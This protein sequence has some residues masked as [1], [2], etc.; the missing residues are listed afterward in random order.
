MF[1]DLYEQVKTTFVN[2]SK[3]NPIFQDYKERAVI[4]FNRNDFREKNNVLMTA[5]S[6]G[7]THG[8]L[9]VPVRDIY[10]KGPVDQYD[11]CT[12]LHDSTKGPFQLKCLQGEFIRQGGQET[13]TLYPSNENIAFW[14]SLKQWIYVKETIQNIITQTLS[15]N[16][17]VKENAMKQFY[18]I[19][20]PKESFA[21]EPQNGV[22]LFWFTHHTD[23]T[24][25]TTFLGRR[26][27]PSIPFLNTNISESGS[28]IFFTSIVSNKLTTAKYR[29]SSLNGFSLYFNNSITQ[30]FNNKSLNTTNEL[31]SLHNGG[32]VTLESSNIQLTPDVNRLYGFLYYAKGQAYYK[33]EVLSDEFGPG[34][35]ELPYTHLQMTQEPFAPMISFEIEKS[36]Q[37]WGCDYPFCDKR[38]SGFKMKWENDGW[39]GPS[40]QYR[41]ESLNQIQ[42]PLKKNYFSF[43]NGKCAIRSKF[44]FRLNSFITLTL[45]LTIQSNV[46]PGKIA[47]PLSLWGAARS[48]TLHMRGLGNGFVSLNIGTFNG[49]QITTDGPILQRGYPYLVTLNMN[50]KDEVNPLTLESVNIGA[51]KVADLQKNA[52]VMKILK[53]SSN[54]KLPDMLSEEPTYFKIQS[55]NMAFDLFWIHLFDYKLQE[56]NLYRESRADWGYLP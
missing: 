56:G 17:T 50:R 38:L 19:G 35:K 24:K 29:I 40:L 28:V 3:P 11:F 5:I 34:I 53:Q 44:S 54:I 8:K 41:G 49:N 37:L 23:I 21:I 26:I 45:L 32:N 4:G 33:L 16:L 7:Q 6:P 46:D 27:R 10:F 2:V 22:E 47:K 12:E 31:A 30:V 42:F 18:G 20:I 43:P 36:P 39:G 48:P 13:G 52:D 14:N 25:P 9:E 55:E 1:S 15:S 51:A